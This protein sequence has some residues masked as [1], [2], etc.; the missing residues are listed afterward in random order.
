MG[1]ILLPVLHSH[2]VFDDKEEPRH[3]AEAVH[4]LRVTGG[5]LKKYED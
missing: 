4:C 5:E 3:A 1:A 2:S